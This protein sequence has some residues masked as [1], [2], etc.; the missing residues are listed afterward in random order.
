[1]KRFLLF[2]ILLIS[3]IYLTQASP[4][5]EEAQK[6]PEADLDNLTNKAKKL[7]DDAKGAFENTDFNGLLEKAKTYFG[8]ASD[9]IRKE[10][11]KM[12]DKVH[13]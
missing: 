1:M 6:V 2:A 11:E 7:L 4:V 9:N 10:I 12:A 3:I 13:D 5:P 8:Q